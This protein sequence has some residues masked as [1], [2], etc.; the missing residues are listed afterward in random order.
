MYIECFICGVFFVVSIVISYPVYCFNYH[1]VM[2]DIQAGNFITGV[3]FD[4]EWR[5]GVELGR[6]K[7]EKFL[8]IESNADWSTSKC[9]KLPADVIYSY[10]F[11]DEPHGTV[12]SVKVII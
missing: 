8:C 11:P 9:M 5:E 7:W 12:V 4:S 6:L 10:A 2:L 1:S 3:L